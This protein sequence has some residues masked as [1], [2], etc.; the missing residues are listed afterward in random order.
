MINVLFSSYQN[1]WLTEEIQM[2]NYLQ[3]EA[4][5]HITFCIAYASLMFIFMLY[6]AN[7]INGVLFFRQGL[8]ETK[9]GIT[10]NNIKALA[11]HLGSENYVPHF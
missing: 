6:I 2:L 7:K 5:Q 11:S 1:R 10:Y 4:D 3:K 8:K 9:S